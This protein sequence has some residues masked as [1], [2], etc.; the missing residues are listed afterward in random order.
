MRPTNQSRC[1]TATL[2]AVLLMAVAA[3]C[4]DDNSATHE[5]FFQ[6]ACDKISGIEL[7]AAFEQFFTEHPE[8]SLADWAGFLPDVV[9]EMDE[10]VAVTELP[11]PSS[12]DAKLA[13]L[14][15][16][17]LKVQDNFRQALA[18]AEDSDQGT[19]DGV[20]EQNQ[21]VDVAAMEAAMQ[22]VDGRECPG[23]SD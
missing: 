15:T 6:A 12:D 10:L 7:D 19:F 20:V 1:H 9:S 3:G 13:T 4:G 16:A 23:P 14:K 5:E 11:H 2:A 18:A 8:A 22:A 21:N 17:V